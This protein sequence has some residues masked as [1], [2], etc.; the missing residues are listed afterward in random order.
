MT[1]RV[2]ARLHSFAGEFVG[3]AARNE[4]P[5]GAGAM[6]HSSA[7]PRSMPKTGHQRGKV[8]ND[9]RA[10]LKQQRGARSVPGQIL[11]AP[12]QQA[13][14]GPPRSLKLRQRVELDWWRRLEGT[15]LEVNRGQ[16]GLL[17]GTGPVLATGIALVRRRDALVMA[18]C[19]SR[20][21]VGRV[22]AVA[23]TAFSFVPRCLACLAGDHER[24][25]V[26]AAERHPSRQEQHD[27]RT[28]WTG[29]EHW[30]LSDRVSS[31]VPPERHERLGVGKPAG[32]SGF[33]EAG[34][35]PK[36]AAACAPNRA[37]ANGFSPAFP[38]HPPEGVL[39]PVEEDAHGAVECHGPGPV[40][41]YGH[42]E[43]RWGPVRNGPSGHPRGRPQLRTLDSQAGMA[44][45]L[46]LGSVNW[47]G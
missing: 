34:P 11:G 40:G 41:R 35:G 3:W 39:Q 29:S 22:M 37:L 17:A 2:A 10:V 23:R 13:A 30:G 32:R 1:S 47:A 24:P 28:K 33:L 12:S 19:K 43:H 18:C 21:A 27:E 6:P 16:F 26:A 44:R 14:P 7:P 46:P 5:R 42:F 8:L 4:S 15:A 45:L 9:E 38:S 20:V 36:A 31:I 25:Q